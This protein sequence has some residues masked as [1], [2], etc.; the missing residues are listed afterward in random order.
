M[1]ER[2]KICKTFPLHYHLLTALLENQ[3]NPVQKKQSEEEGKFMKTEGGGKAARVRPAM[4]GMG[5][6]EKKDKTGVVI[7][8]FQR[9]SLV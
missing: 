5:R 6:I 7:P 1:W 4:L 8:P 9:Y 3:H 2:R